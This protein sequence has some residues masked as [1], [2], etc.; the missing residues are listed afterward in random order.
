MKTLMTVMSVLSLSMA[1]SVTPALAKK[2]AAKGKSGSH[3]TDC[4]KN[5]DK[6]KCTCSD[7]EKNH[8]EGKAC[9]CDKCEDCKGKVQHTGQPAKHVDTSDTT[10]TSNH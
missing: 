3:C 10:K 6:A 9:K 4:D 5:K 1:L 8:E 7:C 2:G